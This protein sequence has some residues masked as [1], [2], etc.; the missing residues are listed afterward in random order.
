MRRQLANGADF[1]DLA[2]RFSTDPSGAKGGDMG[3]V[4]RGSLSQDFESATAS[5]A[6]GEIST[7]VETIYGFHLIRVTAIKPP[8]ARSFTDV[9][10][11][12]QADLSAERCVAARDDVDQGPAS[13]GHDCVPQMR[14]RACLLALALAGAPAW[15]VAQDAVK[16]SVS[17]SAELTVART[18]NT[19]DTQAS[20]NGA[21]W[22]NYALGFHSSLFD[23]RILKYD[24]EVTF[25]TNRQTATGTDLA[26]QRG[27][28][29]DLGFQLGA[30]G[31]SSGAFPF[32]VQASRVLAESDGDLVFTN[33]V[34]GAFATAPGASTNTFETEDRRLNIG[35]QMNVV[36]LPRA[37]VSYRRG[38]S[39]VTGGSDRAAQRDVDLS[40]SVVRETPRTRQAVRFQRQAY[41]YVLAQAF[42]QR[43]DNL[44]YDF[45]ATVWKHFQLTGRAGNRTTFV[46]SELVQAPI[47]LGAAPYAPPPTDGRAGIRYATGGVSYEPNRRVA[48]RM[49]G[50]WDQQETEIA[51]TSAAL[52]NGTVH[53]E[54]LPGLAV[55]ASGITGQRGQVIDERVIVVDTTSAVAGLTYAGGPRWLTVGVAA[56]MG[57]GTNESPQGDRGIMRSAAREVSLSS[58]AG[59]F[60][61][62]AGYELATNRDGLL[63]Y[64]NFDSER[65]RGSVNLQTRR[66]SLTGN[67][68]QAEVLRGVGATRADHRQQTFSA[69]LSARLWRDVTVNGMAGGFN[70]K[71]RTR[72]ARAA[73]IDP[74]SGASGRRP[75]RSARCASSV[76]SG[77]R[78]PWPPRPGS[79]N[80][81]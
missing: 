53:V 65:Y 60:G 14:A 33:P 6:V 40:A 39:I 54:V 80:G 69:A 2:K 20:A 47:D 64:G 46:E 74:S 75:R 59:W 7:V 63:D 61:V 27:R 19:T 25:R 31:L 5:L 4:H 37:E 36:G 56:N 62:G 34:R 23:P 70:T 13:R 21:F 15:A 24:T 3:L 22:Q 68:D 26:D 55:N 11:R 42:S 38:Q 52:G 81:A 1:V 8:R 18:D 9:G 29:A 51:A 79:N 66:I 76:G 73:S 45:T 78:T 16:S 41:D 10:D 35:A 17:G 50:T 28:Q 72:W 44:D 58:S 67:A 77:A 49:N 48:I 30:F 43:L 32:F 12:L 71:S 57:Q